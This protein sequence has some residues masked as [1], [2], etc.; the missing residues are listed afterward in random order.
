MGNEEFD[1]IAEKIGL[2]TS[3]SKL[4]Y[5]L[6]NDYFRVESSMDIKSQEVKKKVSKKIIKFA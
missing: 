5:D 3:T 6:S 1:G 4:L 2:S